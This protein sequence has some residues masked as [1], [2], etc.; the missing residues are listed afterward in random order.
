MEPW[1]RTPTRCPK[2][3]RWPRPPKMPEGAAVPALPEGAAMAQARKMPEGAVVNTL[4]I[5]QRTRCKCL[6]VEVEGNF[7][8]GQVNCRQRPKN[9]LRSPRTATGRNTPSH[10][11][12]PT[13]FC[14]SR[15]EIEFS[16]NVPHRNLIEQRAA[17]AGPEPG[18]GWRERARAVGGRHMVRRR[19]SGRQRPR[20][21]LRGAIQ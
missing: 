18:S 10:H 19:R 16:I 5:K 14:L 17:A 2:E 8:L 21:G 4:A 15:S 3:P 12:A 6:K 20:R 9:P 13:H 11:F 7:A 1:W